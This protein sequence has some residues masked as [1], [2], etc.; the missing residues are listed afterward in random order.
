MKRIS[1]ATLPDDFNAAAVT[2]DVP[3]PNE[4]SKTFRHARAVIPLQ[5]VNFQNNCWLLPG[6]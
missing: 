4:T 3:S 1:D 2:L 6:D 5:I